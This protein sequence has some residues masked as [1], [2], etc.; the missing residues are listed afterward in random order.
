MLIPWGIIAASGIFLLL[1]ILFLLSCVL[2]VFPA[3]FALRVFPIAAAVAGAIGGLLAG[4]ICWTLLSSPGV[5]NN[6]PWPVYW[7]CLSSSVITGVAT[8]Y[9]L[10][11]MT[12]EMKNNPRQSNPFPPPGVDVL[13]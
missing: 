9:R 8:G 1:G 3:S 11:V 7:S 12:R 2:I 13:P 10:C 5:G 4:L 6:M